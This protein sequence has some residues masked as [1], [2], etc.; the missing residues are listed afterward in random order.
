[1]DD[2]LDRGDYDDDTEQKV[3][4]PMDFQQ[5]AKNGV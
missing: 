1:M 2:L 4:A 3:L 5:S